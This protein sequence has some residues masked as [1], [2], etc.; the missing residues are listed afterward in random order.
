[1]F[2]PGDIDTEMPGLSLRKLAA[3]DA[4]PYFSAVDRNRAHLSQFED[5]TSSKYPTLESVQKSIKEYPYKRVTEFGD[6]KTSM[7]IW[8]QNS[9]VG[10]INTTIGETGVEVG[11]WLDEAYTG[12]GYATCAVR[13]LTEFANRHYDVV[14]ATVHEGNDASRAVLERSDY[15]F[16]RTFNIDGHSID[17]YNA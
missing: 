8:A 7:G 10:S 17:M 6:T 12:M 15:T 5:Q 3:E 1:M 13:A 16:T 9:F 11:Y 4:V 14:Y 2:L